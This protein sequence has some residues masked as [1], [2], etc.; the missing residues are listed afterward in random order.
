[1]PTPS[2][3]RGKT[4]ELVIETPRGSNAKLAY[5]PDKNAFVLRHVL[6][7]GM[8][9]PFDFGFVP[10][11]LAEDGDPVDVIVLSGWS[12]YPGVRME[13]RI[14]GALLGEEKKPGK[15]GRIRN[16]RL[17]AVP[18]VQTSLGDVRRLADLP[19]DSLR[20]LEDFFETYARLEGKSFRVTGRAGPAQ[21]RELLARASQR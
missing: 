6:P 10:G 18:A 14:L 3:G 20:Q 19:G 8:A 9:F 7:V 13:G 12:S 11:T 16:D 1:M 4:V 5:E 2:S 17:L 21:A 15:P